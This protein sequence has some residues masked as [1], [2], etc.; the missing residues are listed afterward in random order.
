MIVVYG[1]LCRIQ[2]GYNKSNRSLLSHVSVRAVYNWKLLGRSAKSI[3][4]NKR[5]IR[6]IN[7][8]TSALN[9]ISVSRDTAKKWNRMSFCRTIELYKY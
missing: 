2:I 9:L 8:I 7:A 1:Y 4:C 6:F 3:P 5:L